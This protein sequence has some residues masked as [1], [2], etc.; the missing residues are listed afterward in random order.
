MNCLPKQNWTVFRGR[1]SITY[2]LQCLAKKKKNKKTVT[3]KAN[4]EARRS[5][6]YLRKKRVNRNTSIEGPDLGVSR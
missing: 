2:C 6:R 3:T 4:E 1:N 5:Y